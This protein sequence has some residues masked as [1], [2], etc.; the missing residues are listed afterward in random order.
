[1]D[2]IALAEVA[3]VLSFVNFARRNIGDVR[4][5]LNSN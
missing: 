1:M 4:D 5:K 2:I 3:W